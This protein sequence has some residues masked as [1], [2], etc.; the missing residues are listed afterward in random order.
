VY[1]RPFRGDAGWR[2]FA[3]RAKKKKIEMAIIVTDLDRHGLQIR[4][5]T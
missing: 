2:G 3:I 5:I 1:Y 4:A